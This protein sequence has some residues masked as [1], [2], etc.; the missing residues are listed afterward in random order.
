MGNDGR[1]LVVG[2]LLRA[3]SKPSTTILIVDDHDDS[4]LLLSRVLKAA[5]HDV[6]IANSYRDAM[7]LA[8]QIHVDVLFADIALPDGDG[9]DLLA[10][11]RAMRPGVRSVAFTGHSFP[12]HLARF[13]NA[14]FAATLVKP[15]GI[16]AVL[17]VL[18][19]VFKEPPP[20]SEAP[21]IAAV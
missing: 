4:A 13:R 14:G 16:D 9:C 3:D 19:Q 18:A 2:E 7:V 21:Q 20:E 12:E 6:H 10:E 17:A 1:L 8:R 11:I 15:A 5:G